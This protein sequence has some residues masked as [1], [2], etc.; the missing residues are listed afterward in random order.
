MSKFCID[1]EGMLLPDAIAAVVEAWYEAQSVDNTGTSSIKLQP[2]TTDPLSLFY[3]TSNF[4]NLNYEDSPWEAL[5]RKCV[6]QWAGKEWSIGG[7]YLYQETRL[8]YVDDEGRSRWVALPFEWSV[9][10]ANAIRD[11]AS[12]I[13]DWVEDGGKTLAN[14]YKRVKSSNR[15]HES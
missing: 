15:L 9:E 1:L 11:Y 14:A 7:R 6:C 3:Q 13:I 5:L 10:N 8:T 12:A 2:K 4:D